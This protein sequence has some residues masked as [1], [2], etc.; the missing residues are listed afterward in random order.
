MTDLAFQKAKCVERNK[1]DVMNGQFICILFLYTV[2]HAVVLFP[3]NIL[4]TKCI[5]PNGRSFVQVIQCGQLVT[6]RISGHAWTCL[7]SIQV[8]EVG[9]FQGAWARVG[10]VVKSGRVLG[11]TDVCDD[12]RVGGGW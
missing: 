8:W 12:G 5:S 2:C 9:K 1:T 11:Q 10:V 7:P 4:Q 3:S 6:E